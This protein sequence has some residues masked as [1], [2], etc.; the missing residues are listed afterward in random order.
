MAVK[1][2]ERKL[3][4]GD[5]SL[6][7]DFYING[8]RFTKTSDYRLYQNEPKSL[9]KEKIASATR[10]GYLKESHYLKHGVTELNSLELKRNALFNEFFCDF[11]NT[12]L[13]PSTKSIWINCIKHFE[14]CFGSKV[15]FKR[16]GSELCQHFL[17]YLKSLHPNTIDERLNLLQGIEHER[18]K[19]VKTLQFSTIR[20]YYLKFQSAIKEAHKQGLITEDFTLFVKGIPK[21]DRESKIMHTLTI[22]EIRKLNNHTSQI[23]D[24]NETKKAFV[25]TCLVGLRYSD[26]Y[27]LKWG[28]IYKVDNPHGKED[29][30]LIKIKQRKTGVVL[31]IPIL[32]STLKILGERRNEKQK[33]FN[34]SSHN[35][36]CNRTLKKVFKEA[37]MPSLNERNITMH[38]GRHTFGVMSRNNGVELHTIKSLLGH[39]DIKSTLHYSRLETSSLIRSLY[40]RPSL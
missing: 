19:R 29:V 32:D 9:R 13:N 22:D 34:I 1:L 39:R 15:M 37:N 23:K 7:F 5:V 10:E 30:Y 21:D 38:K 27:N 12:K 20:L 31:N 25:F 35:G 40:S 26:C 36:S 17:D 14:K 28:D 6:Y 2:R 4:N 16:I 3:K 24:F 18:L 8:K 33:V 11:S